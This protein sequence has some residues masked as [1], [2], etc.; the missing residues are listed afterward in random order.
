MDKQ[1]GQDVMVN[2][3]RPPRIQIYQI[4]IHSSKIST[5]CVNKL[6]GQDTSPQI[7]QIFGASKRG[8]TQNINIRS[9]IVKGRYKIKQNVNVL[10]LTP[11]SP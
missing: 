11:F 2:G 5:V 9:R 4:P 1:D 7:S 6:T 3:G 10:R 8:Q